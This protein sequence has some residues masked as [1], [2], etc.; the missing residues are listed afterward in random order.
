M[1]KFPINCLP[2]VFDLRAPIF[3]VPCLP[4]GLSK[5]AKPGLA[6]VIVLIGELFASLP[7][8]NSGTPPNASSAGIS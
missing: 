5:T 4:K 1:P 3:Y 2:G 8:L 6:S 7:A